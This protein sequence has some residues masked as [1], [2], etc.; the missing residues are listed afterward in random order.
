MKI[1]RP[2]RINLN[3][4]IGFWKQL[5]MIIIGT[6]ISL[7]LTI[8]AAQYMESRQR[9]KDRKLSAL[10]VMGNI[11]DFANGIE[12]IVEQQ[13]WCD[14]LC[15]WLLSVPVEDLEI[16]PDSTLKAL[17]T[18]ALSSSF[19]VF[20][21]A[22]ENIFSNNIE[23]WKNMGNFQFINSVGDCF[24]RMHNIEEYWN[25]RVKEEDKYLEEISSNPDQYPGET[26]SV[27]W[28]LDPGVRQQ[29]EMKHNWCCWLR[30]QAAYFRYV[31]KKNMRVIGISQEELGTF[32][33][34]F[35]KEIVIADKAPQDRDFYVLKL[36]PDNL[37]T[38]E[39]Y[40]KQLD[41]L[42]AERLNIDSLENISK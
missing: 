32:M 12:Q 6:T 33:D 15:A 1:L 4:K 22:A 27:K 16:L 38:M 20:D 21:K 9:A 10:M 40:Q 26:M 31:N 34:N 42:K 28:L 17:M 35:H 3:N 7:F 18:K 30:Y 14:T 13:Q 2:P 8:I 39:V 23:T 37:H 19:I 11:E 5:G 41:S 24:S 36:N 25:N 29:M